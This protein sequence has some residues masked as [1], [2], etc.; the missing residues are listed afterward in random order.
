LDSELDS[1]LAELEE[2]HE[3]ETFL[4][5]MDSAAVSITNAKQRT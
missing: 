5:Q 2:L 4:N 3:E 1:L